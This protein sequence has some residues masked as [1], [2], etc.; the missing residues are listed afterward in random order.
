MSE[1]VDEMSEQMA[2][3]SG[4][5]KQDQAQSQDPQAKRPSLEALTEDTWV[6]G[7]V[8]TS[9]PLGGLGPNL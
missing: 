5:A 2:G 8:L 6:Q 4:Q 9:Y 3:S 1:G 7:E